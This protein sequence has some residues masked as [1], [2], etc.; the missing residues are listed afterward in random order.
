M[1]TNRR[2]NTYLSG[3]NPFPRPDKNFS[4]L[5]ICPLPVN[6]LSNVD[7]LITDAGNAISN[8]DILITNHSIRSIRNDRAGHNL[9]TPFSIR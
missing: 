9:D 3:G 2:G 7:T 4:T 6:I 1:K 5:F 8:L